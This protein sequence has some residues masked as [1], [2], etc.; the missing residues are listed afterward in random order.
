[1]NQDKHVSGWLS[2]FKIKCADV[3]G[4]TMN[5]GEGK[6]LAHSDMAAKW[7]SWVGI[8]IQ[9]SW[10]SFHYVRPQSTDFGGVMELTCQVIY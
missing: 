10:P 7:Q 5:P 9:T 1:M 3:I 6:W 4:E 2:L 8:T